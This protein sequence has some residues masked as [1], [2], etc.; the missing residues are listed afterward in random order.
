MGGVGKDS[1]QKL[2]VL[3]MSRIFL[4]VWHAL[5]TKLEVSKQP[6]HT[7]PWLVLQGLTTTWV[8]GV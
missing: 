2:T 7:I 5:S 8:T 1:S 4:S 6:K 3:C